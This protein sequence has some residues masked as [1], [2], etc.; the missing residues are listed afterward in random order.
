[1]TENKD[2]IGQAILDY[3]KKKNQLE[4][5]VASDICDDDTIPV[6]YLFRS[7][8][9][10]PAIEKLALARCE[11]KILDI[12][13]AAGIHS[14]YLK[15]KGCDVSSIDIS[16]GSVQ[17]M[18]SI[19]L[20]AEVQDFKTIKDEKFDT[21]LLLMNGIGIAGSLDSLEAFL[22]HAKSVLSPNGKIICD[23]T[24]VQYLYEDDEGGMWVDLNTLYY[25][26]FKFQMRYKE[27]TTDWFDWL[28]ADFNSFEN[29][30]HNAGLTIELIHEEE[31]QFLVELK[32]K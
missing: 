5:M 13:A 18:Q 20:N 22:I 17:Y 2:A 1:M 6:S 4:I 3:S 27:Y 32:H 29:A 8:G 9:E 19:G 21:L 7:Y 14:S 23:S 16:E 12:G 11:G 10:M 15:S 30:A 25:G 31:N 26:N 24:D 28:Y